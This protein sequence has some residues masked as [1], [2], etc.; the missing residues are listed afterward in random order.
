M[1]RAL[2][3][4]VGCL[5]NL[6]FAT[7]IVFA[8]PLTTS[9]RSIDGSGYTAGNVGAAGRPLVR[10]APADYPRTGTGDWMWGEPLVP[11]PR[12]L[13]NAI[14]RQTTSILNNRRLSDFVWA[15][16]QFLDHDIDLTGNHPDNGT[17]NIPIN[18]P[19]DPLGPNSIP[20]D[21][22]NF[23]PATG[24]HHTPRQQINAITSFIDASNVYGSD[25]MRAFFLRTFE[26]GRLATSEGNLLPFNEFGLPNAGGDSPSLFLAGDVRSNEQVGLTAMHTLFVREH[27]RLADRI[28]SKYPRATD[29]EIYQLARKIVGAEM[30]II[31]YKE[32]LPALLGPYAPTLAEYRGWDRT[33]DPSIANEFSTAFFRFGH[34]MLSPQ[35]LL[36]DDKGVIDAL[37]LRDAFFNPAF[38]A[39]NPIAVDY[40]LKGFSQQQA[41]EIDSH[42]VDDVRNFLFGPP[43]AGGLDLASLNIQRGRDHGLPD[44]NTLRVAYGL[45]AVRTFGE[46]SSVAATRQ[47]LAGQYGSVDDVDPWIGGLAEDHLP[48]ASVGP[49]VCLA[50]R[51][52][53]IRLRDGD[54]YFHL[55]DA[56]LAPKKIRSIIDLSTLT[57][58]NV[59]RWNTSISSLPE[60]VFFVPEAKRK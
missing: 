21:R 27:N 43:G 36:A 31:T 14:A 52:Q 4:I 15:W 30:Q 11:N 33:V 51:D 20:F 35:L 47:A 5:G 44:Y 32:F 2:L 22:S 24:T 49:T 16:G 57:L 3:S 6:V 45:N 41:Q 38:I 13:S 48:G 10:V 7:A 8:Q 59:I 12:D 58:A 53:F 40:L 56:D 29:E 19:A 1:K 23:D 54:P 60:N 39:E 46:I 34:S 9:V 55:N 42:I 17:A 50:L 37:G 26:G 25:A 18:D 28:A